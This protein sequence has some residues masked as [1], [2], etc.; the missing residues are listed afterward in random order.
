M[1]GFQRIIVAVD[2]TEESVQVARKARAL[3]ASAS[4]LSLVHVTEPI[5]SAYFDGSPYVSVAVNVGA[6]DEEI[7]RHKEEIMASLGNELGVDTADRHVL[8]GK[9][10]FEIK[11]FARQEQADLIVIGTHGQKGLGL[12]LGSTASSVLHGAPCD[13]LAVRIN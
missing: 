5:N 12:I 8:R 7:M 1:N 3:A 6:F 10:A 11:E 13:V 9:P 2:L 4:R